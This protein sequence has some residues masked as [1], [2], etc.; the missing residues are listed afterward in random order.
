MTRI[1]PV[2]IDDLDPTQFE[3]MEGMPP[4][5]RGKASG[6]RL[7]L[8]HVPHI[9]EKYG[10]MVDVLRNDSSL[11]PEYQEMAVLLVTRKFQVSYAFNSHLELA[12]RAGLRQEVIDAI[13]DGAEPPL[14]GEELAVYRFL[15]E[16]LEHNRT[17]DA[18]YDELLEKLGRRGLI[19]LSTF[20]GFYGMVG[21]LLNAHEFPMPAGVPDPFA[22]TVV[23]P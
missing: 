15:S 8:L 23:R 2:V 3:V 17:S 20:I 18:V 7:L 19:E 12:G 9:A 13:R 14:E 1:P 4:G 16:L 5:P 6:P 11:K 22:S 21:M 10:A